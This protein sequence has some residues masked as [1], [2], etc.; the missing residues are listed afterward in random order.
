M[1]KI[2][3]FSEPLLALG[4]I[5]LMLV[6]IMCP[7][8]IYAIEDDNTIILFFVGISAVFFILLSVVSR[9]AFFI[10]TLTAENVFLQFPL[11]RKLCLSYS[12]FPHVEHGSYLHFGVPCH[13][14]LLS[15]L[16][17]TTSELMHVNSIPNCRDTIKIRCSK[18]NCRKLLSILPTSH[19]VKIEAIMNK[20]C[21]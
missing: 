2:S 8:F 11:R 15:R 21:K 6:S 10:I 18:K 7:I 19:C 16:R 12:D 5:F 4:F 9:R 1:N 17:F 20:C 3:M 13:Y 14:L